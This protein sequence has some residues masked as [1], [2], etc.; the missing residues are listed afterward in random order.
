M[1]SPS[2]ASR[3]T[4]SPRFLVCVV[5]LAAIV[6]VPA[7]SLATLPVGVGIVTNGS[8]WGG[9]QRSSETDYLNF[10][11]T[12]L[13]PAGSGYR[14]VVATINAQKSCLEEIYAFT[15]TGAS[16]TSSY[17]WTCQ[18]RLVGGRGPVTEI[19]FADLFSFNLLPGQ[20]QRFTALCMTAGWPGKFR[21]QALFAT[22]RH[23]DGSFLNPSGTTEFA[24]I[25]LTRVL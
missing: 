11:L 5:A 25:F 21:L 8:T 22:I 24:G 12:G 6:I 3:R 20:T 4:P 15:F 17:T 1:L 13:I 23:R 18:G 9:C 7:S 19:D 10:D 16:Q 2:E 14:N